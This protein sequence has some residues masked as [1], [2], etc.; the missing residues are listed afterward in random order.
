MSLGSASSSKS[1]SNC[2]KDLVNFVLDQGLTRSPLLA[3]LE[4]G[5]GKSKPASW[6]DDEKPLNVKWMDFFRLLFIYKLA[7]LS[8]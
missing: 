5:V 8:F 1:N 2:K 7:V 4:A 3:W 6:V